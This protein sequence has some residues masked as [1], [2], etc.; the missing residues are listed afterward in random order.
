MGASAHKGEPV[1]VEV[2][3][4]SIVGLARG[5]GT[6]VV[7]VHGTSP[8]IWG[9]LPAL[10]ATDHRVVTYDRRSFGA[11]R[12]AAP[13]DLATHAADAATLV[14]TFGV[15]ATLVGW[16]IGGV[17]AMEVAATEPELVNGMVLLEPPLHAKRHPRPAMLAAIV[18]AMM[19]GWIGRPEAGARRF[20]RWALGRRDGS[21]DFDGMPEEWHVR[22]AAGDGRAVVRE[23]AAGT[24]EHLDGQRLSR[25]RSPVRVLHGDESQPVFAHAARRAVRA[26]QGASL[27]EVPRAG[28]L[29][30]LDAPG[31]VAESV[32]AVC[33]R[34]A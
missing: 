33:G 13:R 23:L 9:D 11:S 3:D 6:P 34:G 25:I 16:S 12:G 7:L 4:G 18:G 10:L 5:S 26:I 19:L 29:I 15:P 32:A 21:T 24:G 27:I 22:L 2:A 30:Q 28:H 31:L 8:A 14:R 1:H 17:V 20:L